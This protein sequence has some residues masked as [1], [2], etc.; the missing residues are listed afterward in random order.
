MQLFRQKCIERHYK[1]GS[2]GKLA[3]ICSNEVIEKNT[4]AFEKSTD[5]FHDQKEVISELKI[6][7]QTKK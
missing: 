6:L 4:K 3:Y 7:I 2:F 1:R 5:A